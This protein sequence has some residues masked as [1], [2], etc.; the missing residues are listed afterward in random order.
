MSK[1]RAGTGGETMLTRGQVA[2]LLGISPERVRQLAAAGI[3]PSQRTPLG[4]L[5]RLADVEVYA[6]TRARQHHP[7][8]P[9]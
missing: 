7:P 5:F 3:L 1:E 6:A 4:R 9:Q 2:A 8:D